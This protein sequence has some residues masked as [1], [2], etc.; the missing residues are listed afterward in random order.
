M[1]FLYSVWILETEINEPVPEIGEISVGFCVCHGKLSQS[2]L[3]R[4]LAL[5]THASSFPHLQQDGA[6][7]L[8]LTQVFLETQSSVL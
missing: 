2:S 4:P 6:V 8:S 7:P 1:C 3:T 5:L